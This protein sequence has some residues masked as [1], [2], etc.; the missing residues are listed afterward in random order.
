M[1]TLGRPPAWR[2]FLIHGS[3]V[4]V[5]VGLGLISW[6]IA[7]PLSTR[8]HETEPGQRVTV[9]A[10]PNI[11]I[12]LD[13]DS[14]VTVSNTE[15]PRIELL[16]G[17]AY[18]DVRGDGPGRLQLKVG[19]TYIRDTGTRFSVSKSSTGGSIAVASG[20]VEIQVEM[21]TY[22]VGAHESANFDGI[23]VTGQKIIPDSAIAPWRKGV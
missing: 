23:K 8:L 18:F 3:I 1:A 14:S 15:P 16:R 10:T 5:A 4:A 17:N 21:G 12:S 22:L 9:T 11:D 7:K 6:F 2:H 13:E 19:T 20:Q